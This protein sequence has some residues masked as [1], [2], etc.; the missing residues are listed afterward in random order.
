[1]FVVS[2]SSSWCLSDF[3]FSSPFL[4]FSSLFFFYKFNYWG[5]FGA[6]FELCLIVNYIANAFSFFYFF[7]FSQDFHSYEESN[8]GSLPCVCLREF[9]GNR[10]SCF[11]GFSQDAVL[12][13]IDL[14]YKFYK[15]HRKI[16][17]YIKYF[18]VLVKICLD[19][20]IFYE[21]MLANAN[22]VGELRFS[23]P[24]CWQEEAAKTVQMN[25][26]WFGTKINYSP[27]PPTSQPTM[28]FSWLGTNEKY[29]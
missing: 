1:M 21:F 6:N 9:Q 20:R 23:G 2:T 19:C 18:E 22:S 11:D 28:S 15:T 24:L 14:V 26:E 12:K 5:C 29:A 8:D 25:R 17:V 13:I 3:D 10:S 27:E 16:K 7:I 4:F